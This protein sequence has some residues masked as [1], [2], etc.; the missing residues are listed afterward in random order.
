M[1]RRFRY[2]HGNADSLPHAPVSWRA[3]KGRSLT[4]TLLGAME[5]SQT[6]V[7]SA[8]APVSVTYSA[9]SKSG[10]RVT[11]L[12]LIGDSFEADGVT[13]RGVTPVVSAIDNEGAPLPL[14]VLFV[15]GFR[16]DNSLPDAGSY[17]LTAPGYAESWLG[18]DHVFG[19]GYIPPVSGAAKPVTL[20]FYAAPVVADAPS[21]FRGL[22]NWTKVTSAND[23]AE[24]ISNTAYM[25]KMFETDW[26]GNARETV[27]GGQHPMTFGVD[28]S[29]R[30]F[31]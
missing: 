17:R 3:R 10:P 18:P 28:K 6:I 30:H 16:L 14:K 24:T 27:I 19:M 21:D 11:G 20:T 22:A 8:D 7:P 15:S 5:A 9:S 4:L 12:K 25:L 26:L 31:A 2:H 13:P 23:L 29:R 1:A